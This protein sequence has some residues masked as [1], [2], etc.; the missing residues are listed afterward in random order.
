MTEVSLEGS[1]SDQGS[2]A[3][4]EVQNRAKREAMSA[5]VVGCPH[6]LSASSF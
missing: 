3:R 5:N 2:A 4:S 6:S 1:W